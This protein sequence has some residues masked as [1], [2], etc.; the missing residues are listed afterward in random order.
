MIVTNNVNDEE[1]EKELKNIE[2]TIEEIRERKKKLNHEKEGQSLFSELVDLNH[3]AEHA[4]ENSQQF[5]DGLKKD[6]TEAKQ[7]FK[8][9]L[10]TQAL[11]ENKKKAKEALLKANQITKEAQKII[12]DSKDPLTVQLAEKA[13][14]KALEAETKAQTAI[15]TAEDNETKEAQKAVEEATHYLEALPLIT[16]SV[17]Q[18]MKYSSMPE[19]YS[20]DL[21]DEK[22]LNALIKEGNRLITSLG[23]P[24]KDWFHTEVKGM[25]THIRRGS[26]IAAEALKQ[27]L[28]NFWSDATNEEAT[29]SL[30]V[31]K[32]KEWQEDPTQAYPTPSCI[33]ALAITI[34]KKFNICLV[35]LSSIY[36]GLE[37]GLVKAIEQVNQKNPDTYIVL[38]TPQNIDDFIKEIKAVGSKFGLGEEFLLAC[39]EYA[40]GREAGLILQAIYT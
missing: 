28:D 30:L 36:T 15:K 35:A 32:A 5:V 40:L 37:D 22:T 34:D 4:V 21:S 3:E 11:E 38:V 29:K 18:R 23:Q 26:G 27:V 25:Q 12:K 19:Q 6:Q 17:W 13:L 24:F 39:T 1:E 2:S 20:Q 33:S 10:Q 31:G 14:K 9:G 7:L 8:S 16:Q